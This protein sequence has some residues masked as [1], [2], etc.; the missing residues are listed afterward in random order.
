MSTITVNPSL[1]SH[2]AVSINKW[3]ITV[4]VMLVAIIE[5]LDMTIVN[6]ALPHMMGSLGAT[7]DQITWVLTSYIVSSAIFMP[8]TGLLVKRLGRKQLLIINILG[9]LAASMLCGI[10]T[11]LTEIVCFRILQGVFG[12]SLVPL[13]QYILQDTFPTEEQGKAM[14]IWGIGI[15]TAPILGPTI[16]GYIT[17]IATWRWVFYLNLPV[18]MVALY[19]AFRYIQETPKE[20][21]PIDWHGLFLLATGIACLQVFLDRGNSAG[22]FASNS[23]LLLAVIAAVTL[24]YFLVRGLL[25]DDN[26]VNL[27]L[28][29]ERN[30]TVS[31]VL[32]MLYVLGV[33]STI[34]IQPLMME[35]L[36]NYPVATTGLIMAPR[37]LTSALAMMMVAPLMKK[38]DYR[39]IV[40][41]GVLLSGYGTFLMS[42]YNLNMGAISLIIPSL[43]QGL[44]MG[45]FFVPISTYAFSHLPEHEVPQAAGLFSFGRSL[46]SSIGISILSTILATQ[47]Q[48]S[49]HNLSGNIH[50][51]N[52]AFTK[53]L[54]ANHF[55]WS[56]PFSHARIAMLISQQSSMISF[57]DAYWIIGVLFFLVTPF[58][59]LMKKPPADGQG[60]MSVSH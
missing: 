38:I 29:R 43:V 7:S 34:A 51:G 27:R 30:F 28:F 32:L 37:G 35:R 24:T 31:T 58:V 10:S 23:I 26:I 57:N 55:T 36:M 48:R 42:G 12:A 15:M 46:G 25:I 60:T 44:G 11:S 21:I 5:V 20:K 45:C 3:L 53:W 47:S 14:A 2:D 19:M 54:H 59:F 16:G 4:T 33:F 6:V 18:C 56:N 17:E 49:W 39:Y 8:L 41:T 1:A 40:A 22:W 13:S 9:F 50:F 52:V